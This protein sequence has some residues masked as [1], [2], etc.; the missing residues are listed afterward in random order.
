LIYPLHLR[1]AATLPWEACFA[2]IKDGTYVSSSSP[3]GG[4][5]GEV[6]RLPLHLVHVMLYFVVRCQFCDVRSHRLVRAD[7]VVGKMRLWWTLS[8]V[9]ADVVTYSTPALWVS[10]NWQLQKV[11]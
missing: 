10:L 8:W 4:T 3:G 9:S 6:C 7:V 5:G 2:R 11:V 1:A